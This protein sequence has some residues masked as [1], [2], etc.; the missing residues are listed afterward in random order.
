M[1]VCVYCVPMCVY[2]V[3]F[4]IQKRNDWKNLKAV[5]FALYGIYYSPTYSKTTPLLLYT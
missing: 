5:S 2:I 1:H 3:N 4:I